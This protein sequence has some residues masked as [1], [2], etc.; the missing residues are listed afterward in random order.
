M[1]K[2]PAW[3][4]VVATTITASLIYTLCTLLFVLF[5]NKALELFNNL[6]HGIDLVKIAKETTITFSS[7]FIGFVEIIIFTAVFTLIFVWLY[8]LCMDHCKNKG[9]IREE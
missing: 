1:N 8:N 9:W 2:L 4:S 6:F 3:P 5:S 7:F